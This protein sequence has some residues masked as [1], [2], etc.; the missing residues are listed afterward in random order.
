LITLKKIAG[1]ERSVARHTAE[2]Q[3]FV[4]GV[5]HDQVGRSNRRDGAVVRDFGLG[6]DMHF[7]SLHDGSESVL[8]AGLLLTEIND[9]LMQE[10]HYFSEH[11]HCEFQ[12]H[13]CG[14]LNLNEQR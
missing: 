5:F 1:H 11:W 14:N 3:K 8:H 10:R 4:S 2:P 12:K 13:H 7:K 9:L 6:M